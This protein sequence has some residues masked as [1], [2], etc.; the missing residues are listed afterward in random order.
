MNDISFPSQTKVGVSRT[1]NWQSRLRV[2]LLLMIAS[3]I[4]VELASAQDVSVR[5]LR[6][7]KILLN[8]NGKSELTESDAADLVLLYTMARQLKVSDSYQYAHEAAMRSVIASPQ[9]SVAGPASTN[10]SKQLRIQDER[11]R[12][13]QEYFQPFDTKRANRRQALNTLE[14]Q[15]EAALTGGMT[16]S[17]PALASAKEYELLKTHRDTAVPALVQTAE[18]NRHIHQLSSYLATGPAPTKLLNR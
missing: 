10:T 4:C 13:L 8:F 15:C 7:D 14:F 6:L 18:K 16:I 1:Q 3:L 9:I 2:F 17:A 5:K 12:L 11:E